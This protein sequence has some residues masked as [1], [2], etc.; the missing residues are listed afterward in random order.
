MFPPSIYA[1]GIVL[2]IRCSFEHF[3]KI[4]ARQFLGRIQDEI[5][6]ELPRRVILKYFPKLT[7]EM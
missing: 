4:E 3:V 6:R 7:W 2:Y 1:A 5:A